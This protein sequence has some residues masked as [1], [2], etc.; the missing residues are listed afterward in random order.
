MKTSIRP[1]EGLTCETTATQLKIRRSFDDLPS[2]IYDVIWSY[3]PSKKHKWPILFVSKT[4]YTAILPDIYKHLEL[5]VDSTADDSAKFPLLRTLQSNPGLKYVREVRLRVSDEY[6]RESDF[7][8]TPVESKREYDHTAEY[9]EAS[10]LLQQIPRNNLRNFW[11]ASLRRIP[12]KLLATLWSHQH[13]LRNIELSC[14][15]DDRILDI[16]FL[17]VQPPPIKMLTEVTDLRI[18]PWGDQFY[19]PKSP[20]ATLQRRPRIDSLTLEFWHCDRM[21]QQMVIDPEILLRRLKIYKTSHPNRMLDLTSPISNGV[22]PLNRL[23]L[24]K[25]NLSHVNLEGC[26]HFLMP[27]IDWSRLQELNV[28]QCI[29]AKDLFLAMN[30][31]PDSSKPRLHC[32]T[33]IHRYNED[34]RPI[35]QALSNFLMGIEQVL[36]SVELAFLHVSDLLQADGFRKHT[37]TIQELVIGLPS[38][39]W[40]LRCRSLGAEHLTGFAM[41]GD[42]GDIFAS[43]KKLKR[44]HLLSLMVVGFNSTEE[45]GLREEFIGAPL[46]IPT[47]EDFILT[48]YVHS[49]PHQALGSHV[50]GLVDQMVT[51][52]GETCPDQPALKT[53]G[54]GL[55][56]GYPPKRNTRGLYCARS[57]S[58]PFGPEEADWRFHGMDEVLVC[59]LCGSE[60]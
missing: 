58:I 5:C 56:E 43:F 8:Y 3:L 51:I 37:E 33:V 42:F 30:A 2:E 19:F 15:A 11:W 44:F 47:L 24:K 48:A 4:L 14:S 25:L 26:G 23:S 29:C 9:P 22:V 13:E 28:W 60:F 49:P 53:V 10:L 31:L 20:L 54:F 35:L 16:L 39:C 17:E 21:M 55:I 1:T 18:M 34:E 52:R 57:S 6:R 36:H 12:S 46:S 40:S 50:A 7:T 41:L 27:A 59:G 32:L 38:H 45:P